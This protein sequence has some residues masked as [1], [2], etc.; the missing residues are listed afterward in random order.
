MPEINADTIP[1]HV[2]FP[3]WVVVAVIVAEAAALVWIVRWALGS[4]DRLATAIAEN[5][6]ALDSH[7]NAAAQAAAR[8]EA[9]ERS[10]VEMR[11]SVE[12]TARLVES[13]D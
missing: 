3:A 4:T 13:C 8:L 2:A 6:A 12:R 10:A 1:G 9:L 5:N 11:E 7:A